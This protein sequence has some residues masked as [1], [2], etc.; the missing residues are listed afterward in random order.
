MTHTSTPST[1]HDNQQQPAQHGREPK[2]YL[3]WTDAGGPNECSHGYAEGIPCPHCDQACACHPSARGQESSGDEIPNCRE[4]NEPLESGD[5]WH[6]D[7]CS[8]VDDLKAEVAA[9]TQRAASAE[10]AHKLQ[11]KD[12]ADWRARAEAAEQER[13]DLLAEFSQFKN[14]QR[15]YRSSLYNERAELQAENKRLRE[16]I[17]EME[18]K[19][20]HHESQ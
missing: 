18:A 4:C 2:K 9:L 8:A 14:E 16:V 3:P 13:R 11:A 10:L 20:Q 15:K 7:V 6:H 5:E 1:H 12:A 19:C 17:A